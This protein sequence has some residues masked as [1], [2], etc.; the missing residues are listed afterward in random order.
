VRE[1]WELPE[2]SHA[3][4]LGEAMR[5]VRADLAGRGP[6]RAVVLA[7][8]FVTGGQASE[9]ER[10][11]SVG[12]VS[13]VSADVFDGADYVALGHLHGRQTIRPHVRYSGSPLAYSFS[14]AGHRKGSWL[15]E[16]DSGG[17]SAAE[18]VDAPV[19]RRVATV[20]GRLESLLQDPRHAGLEDC[21]LKVVL[22]DPVRPA[23]AMVRL[24]DRFPH[25]LVLGF[26]PDPGGEHP[27]RSWTERV[28]GLSDIEVAAGFVAD[29]RGQAAD[30]PE[31]RLLQ[32]A[33]DCCRVEGDAA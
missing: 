17:V 20:R 14:E 32:E 27:E 4:A 16:L 25:A 19:P 3:A 21:W 13:Q 33:I 23:E 24:R 7:H 5:R 29:V 18:F 9:S 1:P 31:T 12:G 10:D 30:E 22:T 6:A 28:A 15:V 11:I 8:A 26:E 2:R